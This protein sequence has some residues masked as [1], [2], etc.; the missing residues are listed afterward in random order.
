MPWVHQFREHGW[1][2]V[3]VDA[4][5]TAHR[6]R[7]GTGDVLASAQGCDRMLGMVRDWR[8]DVHSVEFGVCDH[9]LETRESTLYAEGLPNAV[10]GF[11]ASLADRIH[12]RIG[13]VTVDR[14][15]LG[16][17]AQTRDS[18]V[19]GINHGSHFLHRGSRMMIL[20]GSRP[21]CADPLTC[22]QR[23]V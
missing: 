4:G 9:V 1:S 15:E 10:E 6:H 8:I 7:H 18:H 14:N 11:L 12:S 20:R 19:D 21:T 23:D 13:V 16:T 22:S 2:G 3:I 5:L 17:K